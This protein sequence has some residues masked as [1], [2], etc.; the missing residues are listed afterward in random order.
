MV[1]AYVPAG[2]RVF[3]MN[4]IAEAYTSRDYLVSFQ[5]GFSESMADTINMGW[6]K[7]YYPVVL[8]SVKFAPTMTRHVRLTQT[9]TGMDGEQWSIH[10][11]RFFANGKELPRKPEWRLTAFPNPW[12][13]QFAFDNSPATRWRTWEQAFPGMYVDVDFGAPTPLDE[14][15]I[16][17]SPDFSHIKIQTEVTD[18]AGK[19][20]KL[21]DDFANLPI[22]VSA[23]IRR[24]ATWEMHLRGL[25]YLLMND[26]DY[27]AG[28]MKDDPEAW[29]LKQI[30]QG[31]GARLYKVT[32]LE[33]IK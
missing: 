31:Y 9:G 3:G 13:I 8:R 10:E 20:V 32:P 7:D 21:G 33:P 4:G 30:A 28:D 19:W 29:G 27:G 12:E 14:I 23:N 1:D 24:A 15:H 11:L 2:E 6:I 17:T 18:S 26:T 25:N 16:E 5:S 22:K